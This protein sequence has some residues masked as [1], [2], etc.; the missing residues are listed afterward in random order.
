MKYHQIK[1]IGR[2]LILAGIAV[3]GVG[4]ILMRVDL[5]SEQDRDRPAFWPFTHG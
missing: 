3:Y 4:L 5:E 2:L 1:G